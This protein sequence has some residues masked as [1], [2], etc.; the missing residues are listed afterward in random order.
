MW[1]SSG[2]SSEC[3][4][5]LQEVLWSKPAPL[6]QVRAASRVREARTW[7][8]PVD[9]ASVTA[10]ES[11]KQ[12]VYNL[13]TKWQRCCVVDGLAWDS[14]SPWRSEWDLCWVLMKAFSIFNFLF[15]FI[16]GFEEFQSVELGLLHLVFNLRSSCLPSSDHIAINKIYHIIYI[17]S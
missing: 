5:A 3:C 16:D 13:T 15:C 6:P 10:V 2:W 14:T 11:V 4:P 12:V 1:F 17:F 9:W 8:R 7:T